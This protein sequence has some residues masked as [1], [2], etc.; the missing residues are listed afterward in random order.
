M[1][2]RSKSIFEHSM[3]RGFI[4]LEVK[5]TTGTRIQLNTIRDIRVFLNK[6]V[7]T[8]IRDKKQ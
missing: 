8:I 6:V 2:T 3:I 4:L 1:K 5:R 7:N